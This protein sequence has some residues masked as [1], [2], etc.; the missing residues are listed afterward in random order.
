MPG[1]PIGYHRALGQVV[2]VFK[3]TAAVRSL[4]F[5]RII[6]A[7]SDAGRA[8]T[9]PNYGLIRRAMTDL[10][11]GGTLSQQDNRLVV[12]EARLNYLRNFLSQPR[13]ET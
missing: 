6:G 9:T 7:G 10:L 11:N 4:D 3:R 2:R 12:N 13:P 8:S 1:K 5:W